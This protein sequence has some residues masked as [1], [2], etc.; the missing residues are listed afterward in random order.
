MALDRT[1]FQG[2]EVTLPCVVRDASSGSA[3]FLV[4]AAAARRWLPGP[5]L[6]PV[7]LLPGRTLLSIACVDYRDNDLGDYDEISIALFVRERGAPRGVPVL[8]TAFDFLRGRLATYIHRLPVNQSFTCEAGRGIWGFPKVVDDIEISDGPRAT[9][10]W[11]AEGRHVFTF[12]LPRGGRARMP[13]QELA[14]YTFL[15][16]ALH[17]TRFV[18]GAEGVGFHLG[19][20]EIV[21]GDHPIADELRVL[22]LPKRALLSVWME[23]MHGRFEAPEKR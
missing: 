22:G 10:T 8:G 3:T 20:A 21:L 11:R 17:R 12:S 16:G 6:E 14:T 5:E 19:G 9:C 18:T 7:E 13:E 2:R 4:E 23:K 1:V 15:D